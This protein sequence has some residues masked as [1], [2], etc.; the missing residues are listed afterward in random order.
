MSAFGILVNQLFFIFHM[1][2]IVQRFPELMNILYAIT[3]NF[4]MLI[5]TLL[6]SVILT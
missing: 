2:D 5:L 1:Y 4:E 6:L 3:G